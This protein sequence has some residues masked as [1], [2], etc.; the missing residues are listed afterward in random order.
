MR[1]IASGLVLASLMLISRGAALAAAACPTPGQWL[2][3]AQT[4]PV[5]PVAV[6]AEAAGR[7]VVVLGETHDRAADH[8]WQLQTVAALYG[9]RADFVLGFEMFPRDVQA[10]LD[11][12]VRGE[13]G[14]SEFLEQTRWDEVWGYPADL[15]LPLFHFAR[16]NRIPMVAL[17]VDRDLVRRVGREGWNAVPAEARQGIGG[18]AE[19]APSYRRALAWIFAHK[20]HAGGGHGAV[21]AGPIREPDATAIE[22][23]LDDPSFAR[24]VEA[25]QLWDRAMAEAA[26]TAHNRPGHPLVAVI[27]GRGHVEHGWGI[28]RQL[29][30]LGVKDVSVLVTV[31]ADEACA[32]LPTG[33][34][35]AVFVSVPETAG[36][37]SAARPRLGIRIGQSGDTVRVVGVA[38]GSV[39]AAAGLRDGDVIVAAAGRPITAS[40]ALVATV[41]AMAPGTWLPLRVRRDGTVSDIVARFP[42]EPAAAR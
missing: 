27:A 10:V 39:A 17:N 38:D 32:P 37:G 35:D 15:Y 42:P 8:R 1:L 6:V 30:D 2:V 12:W 22:A 3:P 11:A 41:Q 34:A 31:P 40:A 28:P 4:S 36:P 14:S 7:A 13:L 29:A 23:V 33:L 16:D 26:A 5:D 21:A 18:P 9:R 20:Q 19:I 25:Q 24:F